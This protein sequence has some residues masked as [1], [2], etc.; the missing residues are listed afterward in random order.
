MTM[1]KIIDI[2]VP[3]LIIVAFVCVCFGPLYYL[4]F[5]RDSDKAHLIERLST[6]N[7]AIYEEAERI[8]RDTL[9]IKRVQKRHCR[10]AHARIDKLN[11]RALVATFEAPQ[12]AG[13]A[14]SRIKSESRKG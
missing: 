9:Q 14:I 3:L 6:V 1:E 4:D 12:K 2:A 7:P 5:A 13:E 10:N 11:D 8:V